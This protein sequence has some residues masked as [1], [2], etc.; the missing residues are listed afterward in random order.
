MT[1]PVTVGVVLLVVMVTGALVALWCAWTATRL[2]RIHLQL[3]S[4]EA[5]LA[6]ALARRSAV[7]AEAAMAPGVDPATSVAVL[8]AAA[9]ARDADRGDWAPQTD[10]SEI[11]RVVGAVDKDP[12][13]ARVC[14]DVAISRGIHNDLAI[15]AAQLR[16][17]RRVRWFRLAGHAAPPR[18][19]D[20]DDLSDPVAPTPRPLG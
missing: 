16:S 2:D 18:R 1:W 14:R 4:A 11:L 13:L 5:T 12:A 15:R 3:A 17:R 20:F 9:R 6:E 7:A 10:L 19:I 8:A